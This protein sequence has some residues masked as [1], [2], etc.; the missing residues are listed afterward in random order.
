MIPKY[1]TLKEQINSDI[2]SN[3][4][5]IG[6][7]LPTEIDLA[8]EYNVSRAT[9][10]QALALLS[11]QGI[12]SKRWGSGNTVIAKSENS[13]SKTVMILLVDG[14]S[15]FNAELLSDIS[16]VLLKN[17]YEVEFHD[18]HNSYQKE[19]ECLQLLLKDIYAGLII[20]MAHSGM[21]STN[22]DLIQLLLKRKT[23]VVFLNSAPK[24]VYNATVVQLDHYGKGYQMARTLINNGYLNIG[25]IFINDDSGSLRSFNGFIDAIRDANLEIHDNAILWCYPHDF[26]GVSSRSAAAINRFLKYASDH[27]TAVYTDD[28]TITTEGIYPLH[29]CQLTPSKS[30]GKEAARTFII[31]KKN[32]NCNSVTIPFKN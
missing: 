30:L 20:Y 23:P 27:V 14:K 21:A 15:A 10:R 31:L 18:T 26:P 5:P 28:S 1:I 12:I 22:Q 7:N 32:G 11:E 24:D 16:S 3:K 9:V 8:K 29:Y 13:K 19:R 2:L 25:G 6:T 4:Y 17:G